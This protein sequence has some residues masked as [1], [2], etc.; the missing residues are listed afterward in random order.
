MYKLMITQDAEDDLEELPYHA[1]NQIKLAIET[2]GDNPNSRKAEHLDS[3][4]Y[5]VEANAYKIL[6]DI[7]E[8]KEAV[9]ILRIKRLGTCTYTTK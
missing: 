7:D 8:S 1:W 5:R 6:Y 3:G 9:I 4:A 2:L